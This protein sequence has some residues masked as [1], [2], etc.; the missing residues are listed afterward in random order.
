MRNDTFDIIRQRIMESKEIVLSGHTNPDGDAIGSVLALA[1]AL[2]N[3]GKDVTVLLETY[4][5]RYDLIPGSHLIAEWKE[6]ER[7]ELF[8]SLDCG[9]TKRL[10]DA[11]P[12][13][14][15]AVHTI[16]IDHHESNCFFGQLNYVLPKASSTCEIVYELLDGF[17][18]VN[19]QIASALYMGL[20]YDTGGFRHSSTSPATMMM[21]ARLMEIGVPFTALYQALF[22]SRSYGELK[23]MAKA[24][25][26]AKLHFDGQVIVSSITMAELEEAG[27]NSKEMDAVINYLKGVMDVNVACF[28]YEKSATEVKGSFRGHDGYDVCALAQKFGGG[29]HIKAAGCSISVPIAQ[30]KEMVLAEIEKML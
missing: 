15:A 11:E 14:L 3:A 9:D 4:G 10:A 19:P 17:L 26:N 25:D 27:G 30:A 2:E 29:G 7:A 20:V 6:G 5:R 28:L 8:I 12:V 22:D 18:P 13:F 1:M 16:N 24:L 23:V 21:A